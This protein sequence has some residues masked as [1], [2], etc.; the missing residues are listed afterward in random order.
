MESF[1]N[2]YRHITVLL[3]VI[4]AQLVLLA[5][6]VKNDQ[7]VRFIRIWTIS[8]V[9]PVARVVEGI[10]GGGAGFLHNYITLHDTNA[11]NRRLKDELGRL[12]MENIFLRNELSTAD[13]AKALQIFESATP[14]KTL[15]ANVIAIAPGSDT[16]VV[17]VNRGSLAGVERG[18]AVVTPDGIVGKVTA[19]Y[20]TASMVQLVT[21]PEFA[22]GVIS[23]KN[24]VRGTM[25]GQG[26][27]TCKVDYVGVDE[28]VEPGEM[29]YTSG[30]D[31]I[32]PRGF[33]AGVVRSVRDGA[34]FK[35][36]LIDPSGVRHGV[37]DL[38]IILQGVHQ[39]IPETPPANQPVYLT[40]QALPTAQVPA[41]PGQPPAAATGV[42]TDADKVR[43]FY[44][45]VGEVEN[46]TYGVG[47]PGTK[48]PDFNIK[49]PGTVPALPAKPPG[50]ATPPNG[51]SDRTVP[52]G[53]PPQTPPSGK[54]P[55][56]ARRAN[57]AAG[58]PAGGRL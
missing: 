36:I 5:V 20:P 15:A 24:G 11:E 27:P 53:N 51:T 50:T 39:N 41:E 56:A 55:D 18:M 45:A 48:P 7:D 33:P 1:L 29:F 14:S 52:P 8:A 43:S 32:F 42:G 47:P 22:A 34:N 25:K 58:A 13:R 35:E 28:K 57:Q 38:L 23:Q 4:C 30:D 17:T 6:Q 12:K 2:R 44:K 21:D 19:A 3:L 54:A 49:L 31:R 10:R 16:K 26:T 37:E 40:P 9:T 46:H